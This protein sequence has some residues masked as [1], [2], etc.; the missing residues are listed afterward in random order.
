MK[1]RRKPIVVEAVQWVSGMKHPNVE[2]TEE[3]LRLQEGLFYPDPDTDLFDAEI[4]YDGNYILTYSDGTVEVKTQEE[5]ERDWEKVEVD[6]PDCGGD[7][8]LLESN[9]D[10]AIPPRR[11]TIQQK[12][13]N[14][15][16]TGKVEE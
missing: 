6:C 5:M 13:E 15:N 2:Q 14:C 11:T 9:E 3:C 10:G 7:G 16:G 4:I 1:Y 8:Y 12:C